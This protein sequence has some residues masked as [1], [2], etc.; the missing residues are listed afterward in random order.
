MM[1]Y[2]ILFL[3]VGLLPLAT[4]EMNI[5]STDDSTD[6]VINLG[7]IDRVKTFLHLTDT[8]SSY[9]GQA[10]Q[11]VKVGAGETALEFGVCGG[12]AGAGDKWVDGGTYIY[13]NST[14]ADNVRVL[15]WIQAL[16]WT[17]VTIT[18]SQII[19][20]SY[21]DDWNKT[22]AD[23][24]YAGIEWDYNQT[25]PA[26]SY[27]DGTFIT[28]ANEGNLNVNSSDF[29]DD[30]D[31]PLESW[32]STYNAT[33]DAKANYQFLNNNFNGSGNFTTTGNI[34]IFNNLNVTGTS[35][36]GDVTIIGS[37][38]IDA[39]GNIT[40]N[41]TATTGKPAYTT[42]ITGGVRI[43]GD[44]GDLALRGG[45]GLSNDGIVCVGGCSSSHSLND[46]SDLFIA[47]DLEV[48]G[49]FYSDGGVY[50]YGAGFWIDEDLPAYIGNNH[51]FVY[52]TSTSNLELKGTDD[53]HV[54]VDT[55]FE[56]G[57]KS[58]DWTN[59]TLTESQITDLQTYITNNT[60]GWVLN[61]SNIYS[62]DWTNIT[63]TE[64]QI[65]DLSAGG[66]FA[67][68]SGWITNTTATGIN[69]SSIYS[70]GSAEFYTTG[71]GSGFIASGSYGSN[72]SI[73][74]L[75][76]YISS[77]KG[78]FN[79]WGDIFISSGDNLI[80]ETA[81][82]VNSYITMTSKR[83]TI[84]TAG[85]DM[86]IGTKGTT[87]NTIITRNTSNIGV[88]LDSFYGLSMES[89]ESKV[90]YLIITN[91]EAHNS[92]DG[93]YFGLDGNNS[94]LYAAAGGPLDVYASE[95]KG[96]F[97]QIAQLRE[98]NATFYNNVTF[99]E[100]I[101][102]DGLIYGSLAADIAETYW[103]YN[104]SQNIECENVTEY[105]YKYDSNRT[106]TLDYTKTR[107]SC[108][109]INGFAPNEFETGDVVCSDTDND[110][111]YIKLCDRQYDTRV[112]GI[113]TSTAGYILQKDPLGYP[114]A[115]PGGTLNAK[116]INDFEAGDLL[117]SSSDG[118]LQKMDFQFMY[119]RLFSADPG[120]RLEMLKHLHSDVA[121]ALTT[122]QDGKALIKI[123]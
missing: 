100:D 74:D 68:V 114:I 106:P 36:L 30:L 54:F 81:G 40:I 92:Q 12:G 45:L 78:G 28:L 103:S 50:I 80:L 71:S 105:Y 108:H 83:D 11:C 38:D 24:L 79:K 23:T 57:I 111:R 33:Y 73:K 19:D 17:N 51:Y 52:N 94:K 18:E 117:V 56:G 53:W 96:S 15:G 49:W 47:D 44:G 115:M 4:A 20:L 104:M 101:I 86:V 116:C 6:N 84:I 113:I 14:F 59:I 48:N 1:K 95:A 7:L 62:D 97:S 8:P 22:Y 107:L 120:E 75:N 42:T 25:T 90:N 89:P 34:A 69:I 82:S 64:S 10:G 26:I 72:F 13:P 37:L 102:I 2:W 27:A 46:E 16:D 65:S 66:M 60:A 119:D 118:R 88:A 29:W 112:L 98:H 109:F 61:F 121:T 9:S 70:N 32:L 87:G 3:M 55:I 5:L 63:I 93:F 31:S 91:D 99:K 110:A 123:K 122:C 39:E 35:Y 43:D 67:D 77:A 85:D 76:T 58:T 21:G 41:P